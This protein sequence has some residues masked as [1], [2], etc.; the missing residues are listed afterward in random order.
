MGCK[1]SVDVDKP[2]PDNTEIPEY[3]II[4]I[5]DSGVGKTAIIHQYITGR[6]AET[7]ITLG[8]ANQI[9]EVNIPRSDKKMSLDIWDTAGQDDLKNMTQLHYHGSHAVIIVCS[10]D[11]IQ[12]F[13]S[14]DNYH[15]I[16]Q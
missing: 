7:Q 10:V 3:K 12:T 9:K 15:N 1:P 4:V 13:K 8:V 2:Q 6:Y 11:K 5:G 16:V 14:I